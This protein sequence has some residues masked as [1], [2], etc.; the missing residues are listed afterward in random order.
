MCNACRFQCCAADCFE[1]CGCEHCSNPAC[2]PE[3]EDELEYDDTD[4]DAEFE[5]AQA[6]R[7]FPFSG[8]F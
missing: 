3:G 5:Q 1:G 6:K 8:S 2:W 7:N 4:Y